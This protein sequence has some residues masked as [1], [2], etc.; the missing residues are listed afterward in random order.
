MIHKK[1]E[2]MMCCTLDMFR[3]MTQSIINTTPIKEHNELISYAQC[4]CWAETIN[5]NSLN[6]IHIQWMW[7]VTI[8]IVKTNMSCSVFLTKSRIAP[9]ML[10]VSLGVTRAWSHHESPQG[11]AVPLTATLALERRSEAVCTKLPPSPVIQ[12]ESGLESPQP[13]RA[14]WHNDILIIG[15]DP[16]PM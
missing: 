14:L 11:S 4:T 10:F 8:G 1:L 15:A 6:L 12:S 9:R 7:F 2:H 5:Q 16:R 13:I 3:K